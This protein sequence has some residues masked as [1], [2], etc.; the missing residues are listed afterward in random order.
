MNDRDAGLLAKEQM[1]SP[2]KR[3][4]MAPARVEPWKPEQPTGYPPLA[5]L[6]FWPWILT[7]EVLKSACEKKD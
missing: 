1:S 3:L 5:W 7:Y 2:P 4:E 6:L